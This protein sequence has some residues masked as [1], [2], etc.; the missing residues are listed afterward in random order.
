M[1]YGFSMDRGMAPRSWAGWGCTLGTSRFSRR[2]VKSVA[3]GRWCRAELRS[4]RGQGTL[5]KCR[6]GPTTT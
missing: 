4:R 2:P 3:A 6:W 1:T 5:P